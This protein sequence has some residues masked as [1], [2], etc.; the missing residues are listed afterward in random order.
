MTELGPVATFMPAKHYKMGTLGVIAPNVEI[1]V[2]KS[3]FIW[4]NNV[5]YLYLDCPPTK[6]YLHLK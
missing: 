6:K 3:S 5:F 4:L 2:E 1:Q